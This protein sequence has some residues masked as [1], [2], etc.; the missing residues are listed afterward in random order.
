MLNRRQ[1]LSATAA[2]LVT[3]SRFAPNGLA[4]T[5]STGVPRSLTQQLLNCADTCRRQRHSLTAESDIATWIRCEALCRLAA[6]QAA[7]S[8]L[9]SAAL[10]Q[11]CADACELVAQQVK[12]R[13]RDLAR[14]FA[15][16]ARSCRTLV[17]RAAH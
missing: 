8:Q 5:S 13:S 11:S 15:D 9:P 2:L 6:R 17:A 14:T 4:E 16:G 7:A 1:V 3:G 12:S 10:L